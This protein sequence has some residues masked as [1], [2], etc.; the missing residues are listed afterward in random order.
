MEEKIRF[1][2]ADFRKKV[3]FN[4]PGHYGLILAGE[5]FQRYVKI[6]LKHRPNFQPLIDFLKEREKH[7]VRESSPPQQT[8]EDGP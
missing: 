2:Y 8:I 5:E 1:K 4:V 3:R 6:A 7:D